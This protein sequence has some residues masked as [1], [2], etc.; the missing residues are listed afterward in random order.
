MRWTDA[1]RTLTLALAPGSR[2]LPPAKRPID[3]RVTGSPTVRRV[4]FEGK[5]IEVQW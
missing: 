1:T 4:V 3:V 2:M 5:P